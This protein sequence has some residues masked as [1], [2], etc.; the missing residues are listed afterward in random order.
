MY[1]CFPSLRPLSPPKDPIKP[2]HAFID[3]F[4]RYTSLSLSP[5]EQ[6]ADEESHT[7]PGPQLISY[8]R[9]DPCQDEEPPD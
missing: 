2:S 4:S 5:T 9:L 3:L 6:A 8:E 1:S 7:A